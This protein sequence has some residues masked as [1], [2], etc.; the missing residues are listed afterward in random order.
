MSMIPL[1]GS[2]ARGVHGIRRKWLQ[3]QLLDVFSRISSSRN[4]GGNN[5]V[6]TDVISNEITVPKPSALNEE[7]ERVSRE[8]TAIGSDASMIRLMS[9]RS[10]LVPPFFEF[11]LSMR[12]DGLVSAKTKELARFQIAKLNT[13]R[14]CLGSLSTLAKEQGITQEHV[15]C[16]EDRS[17]DLFTSQEV[18][19]MDL[20]KALWENAAE[21]NKDQEL[22]R[23]VRAEFT[24]AQLVE[25]AWA[26]AMYIGLGKM[27]VFS[28]IER[29][30]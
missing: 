18:A 15:A 11:Y 8:W 4:E 22:M 26:I 20:A 12:S 6:S 21:A 24:D 13:C 14:Y 10:D 16:L 25:L 9:Y 1:D 30:S 5:I 19:A 29:D 3:D 28:G 7:V 17:P 2:S 23:R 27:V